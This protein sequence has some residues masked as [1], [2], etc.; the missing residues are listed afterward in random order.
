MDLFH[1][2]ALHVLLDEEKKQYSPVFSYQI[3]FEVFSKKKY[4]IKEKYLFVKKTLENI[5]LTEAMKNEFL[6]LFQKIQQKFLTIQRF[7]YQIKYKTAQIVVENDL[8]LNPIS[9]KDKN[10][11]VIYQNHNKYLF[12]IRDMIQMIE[13]YITHSQ[14]FFPLL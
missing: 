1:T 5:F 3:F 8:S 13:K 10:V 7:I 6:E 9:E 12:V 14:F 2:I 11:I 4:S